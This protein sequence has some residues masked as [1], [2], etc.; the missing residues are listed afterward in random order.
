MN[1]LIYV[2]TFVVCCVATWGL[3]GL[4][5]RLMPAEGVENKP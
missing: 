3:I 1:D 2:G 4:C 5:Q